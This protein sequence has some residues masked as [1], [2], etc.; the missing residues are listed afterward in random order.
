MLG[1]RLGCYLPLHE[2]LSSFNTLHILGKTIVHGQRA[3]SDTV[4]AERVGKSLEGIWLHFIPTACLGRDAR[5][6]SYSSVVKH[7]QQH[8]GPVKVNSKT[9]LDPGNSKLHRTHHH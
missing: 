9:S 1:I 8:L 2:N 3:L 6:H 4:S 7:L 5:L